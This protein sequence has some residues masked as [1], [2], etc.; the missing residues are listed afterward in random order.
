MLPRSCHDG[1]AGADASSSGCC[2][3]AFFKRS[4]SSL[5]WTSR[6]F[7]EPKYDIVPL[8]SLDSLFDR[9]AGHWTACVAVSL[10]LVFSSAL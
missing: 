10:R 7:A 3:D 9:V 5:L 4:L 1:V 6:S 8:V 2:L